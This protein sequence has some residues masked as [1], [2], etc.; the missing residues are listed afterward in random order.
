MYPVRAF[1]LPEGF[2]PPLA[3]SR[4]HDEETIS[5]QRRAWT[6]EW[7]RATADR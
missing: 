5:R 6:Q 3:R 2:S 1:E 4:L 7:Q